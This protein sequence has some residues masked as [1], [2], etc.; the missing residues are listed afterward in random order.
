M[1]PL[2]ARMQ[3]LMTKAGSIRQM[4]SLK[5]VVSVF[6]PQRYQRRTFISKVKL[7]CTKWTRKVAKFRS[8]SASLWLLRPICFP[9]ESKSEVPKLSVEAS[10]LVGIYILHLKVSCPFLQ[11]CFACWWFW[12]ETSWASL[13]ASSSINLIC[14]SAKNIIHLEVALDHEAFSLLNMTLRATSLPSQRKVSPWIQRSL[15]RE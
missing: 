15:S 7:L 8:A 1:C 3:C 2:R 12:R 9:D 4:K 10:H 13:S 6:Y 5:S 11:V 14:P